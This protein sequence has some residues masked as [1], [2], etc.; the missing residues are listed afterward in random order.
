MLFQGFP[1]QAETLYE[2][3]THP[4]GPTFGNQKRSNDV[5]R[6]AWW[7]DEWL[8][9]SSRQ[10]SLRSRQICVNSISPH[11]APE[12]P[13]HSS[14]LSLTDPDFLCQPLLAFVMKGF[15]EHD[16]RLLGTKDGHG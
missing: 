4:L 9:T 10:A 13:C 15:L 1:T 3:C 7:M 12:L 11:L 2:D 5:R 14:S 8:L 16:P 6:M